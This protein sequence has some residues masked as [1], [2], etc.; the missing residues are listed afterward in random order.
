MPASADNKNM[1]VL[2]IGPLPPPYSGPE[3][4]MFYF[5]NSSLRDRFRISF[6]KT[7]VRTSNA[8]KGKT[9]LTAIRAFFTYLSRLLTV[10]IKERPAVVYYP[11][12]ATRM[13]I[14]GRDFWTILLARAFG[15]KV[16]IHLRA[17][18]FRLAF[19]RLTIAERIVLRATFNLVSL[20]LVQA[21]R[22]K[23]QFA[24]ILADEKIR[25]LYNGIDLSPYSNIT[26][27]NAGHQVL[28]LGFLSYAK[29]YCD[30]LKIIPGIVESF[31]DVQFHFCG[32]KIKTERNVFFDQT[33]GKP[34]Q[35]E[36]PDA[37]FDRYIKDRYE[38]NVSFHGVVAGDDKIRLL[39]SCNFL[40]LPSY[41]EGFS[42]AILEALCMG[43]PVICTRVGALAEVLQDGVNGYLLQ[44]GDVKGLETAIRSLLKNDAQ[45]KI[46]GDYNYVFAREQFD[47][48]IIADRLAE[49]FREIAA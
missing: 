37:V 42:M 6:L 46:M 48:E 11:V 27:S 23:N 21:E 2:F 30:I 39:A 18:H 12:T 14:W 22:L 1:A 32:E 47:I 34:L 13:G 31:P 19:D 29:G 28:F 26:I 20:A 7:N 24:G 25:V 45:Q 9:D 35:F 44:P 40:V 15:S 41:S 4:G 5:L 36:D 3:L 33:T 17:G 16:V 49:Y 43:K 8:A 38:R 10:L